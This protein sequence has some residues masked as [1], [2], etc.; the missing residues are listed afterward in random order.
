MN[1]TF[2]IIFLT[3]CLSSCID[4]S[5]QKINESSHFKVISEIYSPNGR[6][7]FVLSESK[8]NIF[9][10]TQLFV[11]FGK[12]GSLVYNPKGLNLGIKVCWTGND[13]IVVECKK[14]IDEMKHLFAQCFK[15]KVT[16]DYR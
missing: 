6:H 3:L 1:K 12:C 11:D 7:K 15:D 9:P 4:E 16:I 13:T 8:D 10:S 2:I 14:N 5:N